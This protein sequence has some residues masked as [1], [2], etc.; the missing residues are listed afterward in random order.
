MM[1]WIRVGMGIAIGVF[2]TCT[3]ILYACDYAYDRGKKAQFI[4][5][6]KLMERH[7]YEQHRSA[8]QLYEQHRTAPQL[9]DKIV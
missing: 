9:E 5:D 2:V 4:Q 7:F 1:K 6:Q 8:P 3:A